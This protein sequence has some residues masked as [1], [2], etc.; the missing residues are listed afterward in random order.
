MLWITTTST[1]GYE[2]HF[3]NYELPSCQT[4]LM[5]TEKLQMNYDDF[6]RVLEIQDAV[7]V[8]RI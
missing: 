2:L 4:I 1:L 8:N 3:E 5:L 7:H 6:E